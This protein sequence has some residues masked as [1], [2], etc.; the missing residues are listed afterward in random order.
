MIFLLK[1]EEFVKTQEANVTDCQ[2]SIEQDDGYEFV[3]NCR[4]V[5]GEIALPC[6]GCNHLEDLP[7]F[8]IFL[9]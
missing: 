1:F 5:D 3:H 9:S 7:L 4:F 6:Q 8:G 2:M